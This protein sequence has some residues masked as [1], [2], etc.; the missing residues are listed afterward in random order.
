M[1]SLQTGRARLSQ[2][3]TQELRLTTL[4]EM[5]AREREHPVLPSGWAGLDGLLGG[6]LL[7][8]TL[9]ECSGPTGASCG[10]TLLQHQLLSV[11]RQQQQFAALIDAFDRF[12][13]ASSDPCLLESLLWIRG[14]G[15]PQALKAADILLRDDNFGL[16]LLDLR[17]AAAR[18][19]RKVPGQ[20]WYRLQRAAQ[21]NATTLVVFTPFPAVVSARLR[22]EF[23]PWAPL[24][25]EADPLDDLPRERIVERFQIH[26]RRQRSADL[27]LAQ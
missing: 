9:T 3:L 18:Q 17:D 20:Q 25:A 4:A 10:L 7:Q 8:G 22:V 1:S 16:V 14:E 26:L 6:G 24:P 15:V 27:R 13:P 2:T 21:D 19:L 23:F 11:A 12:D 5:E